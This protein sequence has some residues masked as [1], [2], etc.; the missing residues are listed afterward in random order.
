MR[1]NADTG[2]SHAPEKDFICQL[3]DRVTLRFDFR[4]SLLLLFWNC[5]SF[6]YESGVVHVCVVSLRLVRILTHDLGTQAPF[7]GSAMPCE[8]TKPPSKSVHV[9]F[10]HGVLKQ[11]TNVACLGGN[12]LMD[13]AMHH[14]LPQKEVEHSEP[15]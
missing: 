12:G 11:I 14:P 6:A 4:L 8:F 5:R 15:M 9:S 13:V 1:A 7:R 3:S 2:L 10:V